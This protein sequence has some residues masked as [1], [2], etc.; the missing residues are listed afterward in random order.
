MCRFRQLSFRQGLFQ[1]I[2][3][4]RELSF[5][6]LHLLR[7]ISDLIQNGLAMKMKDILWEITQAKVLGSGN[8]TLIRVFEAEEEFKDRAFSGAVGTDDAHPLASIYLEGTI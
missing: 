4:E 6:Y 3:Q 2:S 1:L 7:H 5:N 8:L